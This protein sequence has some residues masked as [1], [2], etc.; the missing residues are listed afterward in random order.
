MIFFVFFCSLFHLGFVVCATLFFDYFQWMDWDCVETRRFSDEVCKGFALSA[1]TRRTLK[2]REVTL[3]SVLPLFMDSLFSFSCL[4]W[5]LSMFLALEKPF[6]DCFSAS[7]ISP[8]F[9][10][11]VVVGRSKATVHV[12]TSSSDVNG[13]L[14]WSRPALARLLNPHDYETACLPDALHY[15]FPITLQS[16]QAYCAPCFASGGSSCC[17]ISHVCCGLVWMLIP[18]FGVTRHVELFF[19]VFVLVSTPWWLYSAWALRF[20]A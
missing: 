7:D 16:H 9:V 5:A 20:R 4:L 18:H 1:S 12:K 19:P 11:V 2:I 8:F 10:F 14:G 13:L 3:P 15:Y 17:I 6:Y